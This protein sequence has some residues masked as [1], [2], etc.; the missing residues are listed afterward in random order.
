M[1]VL[2]LGLAVAASR[3]RAVP[4]RNL[5]VV[6][7]FATGS[8]RISISGENKPAILRIGVHEVV[9]VSPAVAGSLRHPK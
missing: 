9:R 2:V 4:V 8:R 5:P 6:T 7:L 3:G 1:L